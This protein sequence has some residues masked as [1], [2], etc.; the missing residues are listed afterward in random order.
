MS[1]F[2]TDRLADLPWVVSVHEH[3]HNVGPAFERDD[4]KDGE[5]SPREVVEVDVPVLQALLI[6]GT[7]PKPNRSVL[8]TVR[9]V[10]LTIFVQ[11]TGGLHIPR[12]KD[13]MNETRKQRSKG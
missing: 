8:A 6:V 4:L 9:R 3:I 1:V 13:R 10:I 2:L 7:P 11:R 12:K 5:E